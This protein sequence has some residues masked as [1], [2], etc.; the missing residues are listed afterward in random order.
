MADDTCDPV[1]L[2]GVVSGENPWQVWPRVVA[3][4][5]PDDVHREVAAS[6]L[7][8]RGGAGFHV[9]AKWAAAG[10][11]PDT[12]VV[13]NG[14]EGDP[15]SFAD[16]LLMEAD[17]DRVVEGLALAC[18]ASGAARGVVLVCSEYPRADADEGSGLE[19]LCRWTPRLSGARHRHHLGRPGGLG[20]RI[21]CRR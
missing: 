1:L 14:D 11:G 18:F 6:G 16:R 13:A 15:G 2:G 8:G 17:P 3:T 4:R 7:R 5:R 21:V 20:R 19:R 9:A 10:R 12:V